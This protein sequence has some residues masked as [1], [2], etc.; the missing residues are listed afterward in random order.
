M[1]HDVNSA[2][3][4]S[5]G[6]YFAST[7]FGFTVIFTVKPTASAAWFRNLMENGRFLLPMEKSRSNAIRRA[8]PGI[9]QIQGV[10]GGVVVAI[11]C[12]RVGSIVLD[13]TGGSLQ[14]V[15]GTILI[16]VAGFCLAV[17][18]ALW[19]SA[20][21]PRPSSSRSWAFLA[22]SL[23]LALGGVTLAASSLQ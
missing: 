19:L 14:A 6:L 11:I 20:K 10:W 4:A 5:L 12:I 22:A 15:A 3:A 21:R 9:I 1:N 16:S 18:V 7:F 13:A 17:C 2:I 23:L 8:T